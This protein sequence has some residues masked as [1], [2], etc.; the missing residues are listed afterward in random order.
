MLITVSRLIERRAWEA[1]A[2]TLRASFQDLSRIQNE[3]GTE[4]VYE[5]LAAT[6]VDV[7][8]YG[9]AE[10]LP[11]EAVRGTVHV[12]DATD[13]R[14]SWFV[15]YDPPDGEEDESIALLAHEVDPRTWRGFWTYDPV[16]VQRIERY[17]ERTL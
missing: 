6:D 8:V 7:H 5:R 3:R 12:G 16:R 17:I 4:R 11:S 14:R 2:G 9:S 1:G 13:F 15:V 10:E